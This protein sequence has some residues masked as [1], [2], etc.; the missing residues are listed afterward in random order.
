MWGNRLG[1]GISAAIAIVVI[2]TLAFYVRGANKI[3][4]ATQLGT[5]AASQAL[6]IVASPA[7]VIGGETKSCDAAEAYREAIALYRKDK[8]TYDDIADGSTLAKENAKLAQAAVSA[9]A[10]AMAPPK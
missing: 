1:W 9:E 5:G 3:S 10:A 6:A 2:G 8:K 4:D 7:A